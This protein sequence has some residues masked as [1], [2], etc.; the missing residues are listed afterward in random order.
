MALVYKTLTITTVTP[1][2]NV[3]FISFGGAGATEE[4]ILKDPLFPIDIAYLEEVDANGAGLTLKDK[5]STY[6]LPNGANALEQYGDSIRTFATWGEL[7][8]NKAC[9]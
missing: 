2:I 7:Y 8:I 4:L 5:M 3:N 1:N 9:V 6:I